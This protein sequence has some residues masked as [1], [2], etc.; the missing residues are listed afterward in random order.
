VIR[1][2]HHI[3]LG[4]NVALQQQVI[5]ALHDS[6]VGGHSGANVTFQKV[7][8]LF[9]WSGMR[10]T[11]LDYVRQCSTCSQAKADRSRYP[12]LLQPLPV[13]QTAWE[14]IFMDFVEGLPLSGHANAIWVVVDKYSKFARFVPLRHP[15]SA[16][17]VAKLL[18]DY[19]NKLHDLPKSIISDWDRIFTSKFWQLLFKLAGIQLRMSSSYH[20][21]TDGQTK[22]VNQCMETYLRCFVHACPGHW[23]HWLPLVEF[24]YNT[25]THSTLGRTPF[26]VIYSYPPSFFLFFSPFYKRF[27]QIRPC[28]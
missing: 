10:T 23:V 5:S 14:I 12:G 20:P 4:S 1:Y 8:K 19:I 28:Q 6:P 13:P 25:S 24:W 21:Q 26:E 15:F 9:Y 22:R 11:I 16:A 2:K 18:M 17:I 3:W 7:S 27:S